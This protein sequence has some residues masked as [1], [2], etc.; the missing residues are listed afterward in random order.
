MFQGEGHN[1][2]SPMTVRVVGGHMPQVTAK[3]WLLIQSAIPK[4]TGSLRGGL[5]LAL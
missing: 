1:P 5:A 3:D 2:S 4:L